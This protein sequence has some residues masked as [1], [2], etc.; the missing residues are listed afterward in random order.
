[1]L[2]GRAV[3][4]AGDRAGVGIDC[5]PGGQAGGSAKSDASGR[6]TALPSASLRAGKGVSTT[7]ASLAAPT[8]TVTVAVLD[9][10]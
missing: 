5:E 1:L 8:V 2:A 7:G 9:P 6:F 3:D 10:P 4:G